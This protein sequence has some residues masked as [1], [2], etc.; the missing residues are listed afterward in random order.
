MCIPN[1]F[2]RQLAMPEHFIPNM[3]YVRIEM[4]KDVIISNAA[5]PNYGRR[6]VMVRQDHLLTALNDFLLFGYRKKLRNL[7]GGFV[8]VSLEKC[9]NHLHLDNTSMTC[10]EPKAEV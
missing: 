2:R 6:Q 9:V 3:C 5:A 4:S 10:R 7:L 8:F 1:F